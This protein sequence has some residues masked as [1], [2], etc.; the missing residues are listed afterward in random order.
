MKKVLYGY[1]AREQILK[2]VNQAVDAVSPTLGAVGMSSILDYGG[3]FFPVESDDGITV[4]KNLSFEDRAEQV[5][6]LMVR[7]ASARTNQEG[8]DGTSTT[9]CLFGALANEVH[10]FVGKNDYKI[11]EAVE[12]LDSG[13]E[14]V[15]KEIQA[16]AVPVADDQIESVATIASLD[17]EIGKIIADTYKQIGR[18]GIISVEDSNTIGYS[19]EVVHGTR[20]NK[21]FISPYF[22]TDLNKGKTIINNPYVLIVDRRIGLNNQIQGIVEK[23]I[24]TGNNN[25]VIFADNVEG[26]ALATLVHNHTRGVINVVCVQPPYTLNDKKE[27]Y[28]DMAALTGATVVSEEAGMIVDN[29][30][31]G[32]LGMCEKIE[33]TKDYTTLVNG[34]GK[35]VDIQNRIEALKL[36]L[37]ESLSESEKELLTQRIASLAGGIGVIRVGAITDT[38]LKAKKYKIEDAVNATKS[39]IAEGIVLGGGSFFVGIQNKIKNPLIR[40]ILDKPLVQM[41]LNA[42]VDHKDIVDKIQKDPE[43]VFDFKNKEFVKGM[44]SK[45]IDSAKVTRLAIESAVSSVK[46]FI[47]GKTV[48]LKPNQNESI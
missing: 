38:E 40:K 16:K 48:I 46:S 45:I 27:W 17:P 28:K 4:L 44:E 41:S 7:K 14:E 47:R 15:I 42:G 34:S 13:L 24:G 29:A 10:Q 1:D 25:L 21:G 12:L 2:G 19:T 5:G 8:G 36:R 35:K 31:L 37:D 33:V 18:D 39:A 32:H 20:F 26:E 6:M 11:A 3:D 22:I 43:L 9:A 23:V 30:E